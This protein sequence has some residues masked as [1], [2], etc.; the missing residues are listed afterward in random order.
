MLELLHVIDG[1]VLPHSQMVCDR[2][3]VAGAKDL[4]HSGHFGVS[5]HLPFL[6]FKTEKH[7]LSTLNPSCQHRAE[8]ILGP[9]DSITHSE[10]CRQ[11]CGHVPDLP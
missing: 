11:K 8:D 2:P 3:E 10:S 5:S 6:S 1:S 4:T 7:I 9:C